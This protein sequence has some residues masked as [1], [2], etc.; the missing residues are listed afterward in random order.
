MTKGLNTERKEKRM[1]KKQTEINERGD[2]E[3]KKNERKGGIA[4]K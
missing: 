3:I 1:K 2:K 4:L